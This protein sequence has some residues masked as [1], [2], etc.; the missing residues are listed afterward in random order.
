MTLPTLDE[1]CISEEVQ[2]KYAKDIAI[3]DI[4]QE[5]YGEETVV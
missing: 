4:I 2:D 1:M 3:N 5:V